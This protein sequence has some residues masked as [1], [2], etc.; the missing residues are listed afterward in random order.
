MPQV[1]MP[2]TIETGSWDIP[3]VSVSPASGDHV[4]LELLLPIPRWKVYRSSTVRSA[5]QLLRALQFVPIVVCDANLFPATWQEMLAQIGLFP[6]PP[7]LIVASR[8]A[9][10][11]LWAEA[12]NLGAYDVLGKPFDVTELTR[13]LSL[14]WLRT[15]RERGIAEAQVIAAVA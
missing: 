2:P 1:S 7:H 14:A 12:L 6:E 15:Q 8:I 5:V 13:S 11:Y 4:E 10:D 3:V 9:D